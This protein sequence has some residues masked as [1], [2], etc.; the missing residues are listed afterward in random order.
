MNCVFLGKFFCFV[1]RVAHYA[2]SNESATA[3]Y[4]LYFSL[5]SCVFIWYILLCLLFFFFFQCLTICRKGTHGDQRLW[6]TETNG[7]KVMV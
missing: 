7:S 1:T 4:V 3:Y 2:A 5:T 6:K